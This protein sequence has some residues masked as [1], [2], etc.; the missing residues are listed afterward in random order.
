MQNAICD[1]IKQWPQSQ[2]PFCIH[3]LCHVTSPSCQEEVESPLPPLE[4]GW[5]CD[6]LWSLGRSGSHVVPVPSLRLKSPCTFQHSPRNLLCGH[7][8]NPSWPQGDEQRG[9][10]PMTLCQTSHPQL[11][12][13]WPQS[14]E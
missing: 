8:N 2:T 9:A 1:R 7:M 6:L 14:S 13:H 3:A 11:T 12:W 4:S 5:S 10:A